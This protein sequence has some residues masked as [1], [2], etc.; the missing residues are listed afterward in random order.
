MSWRK[1]LASVGAAGLLAGC[2]FHPLY[3]D[4]GD[5]PEALAD[6]LAAI[7]VS[8]ISEHFGQVMTNALHDGLNPDALRVPTQ[9]QLDV[10]LREVTFAFA[11]RAD[12]TPSRNQLTLVATW[13]LRQAGDSKVVASGMTKS[14]VGYDVLN[15]DYTNVISSNNNELRAVRDLSDEIQASIAAYFQNHPAA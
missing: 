5:R 14:N 10:A 2:G 6:R 7:K 4:A 12:G 1:R 9:Y 11:A 3:E 13:I 8:Q 15:N